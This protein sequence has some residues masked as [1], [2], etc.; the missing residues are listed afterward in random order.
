MKIKAFAFATIFTLSIFAAPSCFAVPDF[1]NRTLSFFYTKP[2]TPYCFTKSF[3]DLPFKNNS[4]SVVCVNRNFVDTQIFGN[5]LCAALDDYSFDC[6]VKLAEFIPKEAV[7][8][9]DYVWTFQVKSWK[10]KNLDDIPEKVSALVLVYDRDYNLLVKSNIKIRK[11]KDLQAPN[12]LDFLLQEY[13]KSLFTETSE[14]QKASSAK[15]EAKPKKEKPV[16][17]KKEKKAKKEKAEKE[18]PV[19]GS[20]QNEEQAE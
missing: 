1:V 11:S 15:K 20:E 14:I 18:E 3:T 19:N 8:G 7:V 2:G 16:K 6:M 10:D 9:Y 5:V 4:K 12:C 17:E 13:V